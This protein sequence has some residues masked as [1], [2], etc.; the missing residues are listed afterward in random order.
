MNQPGGYSPKDLHFGA[1]AQGKL[2]TGIKKLFK[3]VSSTLGP[4]G[5]TVLI[6]SSDHTRGITVTKDG[7]TVAKS[8]SLLDP[9]ENLAVRIMKEAADR[10]AQQAGDGTTTAIVITEALVNAGRDLDENKTQVLRDLV[11]ETNCIIDRLKK[12]ARKVNNKTLKDVATIS[13]NNDSDLGDIIAKVYERVGRDGVVAVDKSQSS[14]TY[15]ESTNGL[16]I[17]RGFASP[18]FIN[19]QKKDECILEDCYVLVSDATIENILQIE[20]VLKSVINTGKRLLIIAPTSPNVINTLAA[21]VMKETVF[22]K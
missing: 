5:E 4:L 10:T 6:E 3:A 16:K 7:V 18:L 12:K 11:T 19:D 22:L 8:V 21:N 9:T 17:D 20:N 2:I 15:Y 1:E 13:A 14:K